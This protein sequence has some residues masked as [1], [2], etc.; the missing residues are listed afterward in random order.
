M[1]DQTLEAVEERPRHPQIAPDKVPGTA[2]EVGLRQKQQL[3][4]EVAVR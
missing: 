1:E 4:L 2:S 3:E